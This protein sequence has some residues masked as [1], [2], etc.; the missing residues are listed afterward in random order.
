MF[1]LYTDGL[2]ENR[3]REVALQKIF[4]E[5]APDRSLEDLVQGDAG[6]RVRRLPA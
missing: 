3:T 6:R 4:S 2:V 1:L 5:S